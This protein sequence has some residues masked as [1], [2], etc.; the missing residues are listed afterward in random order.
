MLP[1]GQ[2]L[3]ATNVEARASNSNNSGS[4]FFVRPKTLSEMATDA[5]K[6]I[7]FYLGCIKQHL[8][9]VTGPHLIKLNWNDFPLPNSP[10]HAICMGLSKQINHE[11]VILTGR[12]LREARLREETEFVIDGTEAGPGQRFT[13]LWPK[14]RA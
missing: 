5:C 11:K 4:M 12:G 7:Y 13:A 9:R 8:S 1:A 14:F 6:Y 2:Y 10:F 3:Y